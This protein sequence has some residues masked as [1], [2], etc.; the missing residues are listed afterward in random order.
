MF[1]TCSFFIVAKVLYKGAEPC[2]A[3]NGRVIGAWLASCAVQLAENHPDHE[4]YL[5]M[6]AC[7]STT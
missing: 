7:L 4:E 5:L 3:Y 6:A 1:R 2:K